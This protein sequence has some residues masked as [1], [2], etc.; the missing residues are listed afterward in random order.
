VEE[1]HRRVFQRPARRVGKPLVTQKARRGE[2]LAAVY[3]I[4]VV[5][6]LGAWI[7]DPSDV[8][9]P[10]GMVTLL[11]FAFACAVALFAFRER[12]PERTGD[13]AIVGSIVLISAGNLFC[14][15]HVHPG[16]LTPYYIWVGFASPMWFARRRAVAYVLVAV[17]ASGLVAVVDGTAVA[18][19]AWLI[20]VAVLVVAFLTVDSL[21]RA[22]VERERLAAVGEMASVVSHELRNPLAVLTNAIYLVRHA[23]GAALTPDLERHLDL[24]DR[25]IDKANAIIE[26]IVAFVRP[27]HPELVPVPLDQV[28]EEVLETTPP[29]PGVQVERDTPPVTA[30]VDR[31]HLAE[32]LVNLVSNAYEAMPDGGTV[33]ITARAGTA[34][35]RIAVEDTGRGF[36]RS[37]AERFFE[38]FYTTKPAGTGLGL[39]I[40][41]RLADINRGEIS[42]DSHPGQG[43]RFT[44]T[45]PAR[46]ADPVPTRLGSDEPVA[47][48]RAGGETTSDADLP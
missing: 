12:L 19:A 14:R 3:V 2:I 32:V 48:G 26:H 37:D 4:G 39:A 11:A 20:T 44:V 9:N 34:L 1:R 5:G 18:A 25:E 28:I 30:V 17:F 43:T 29:P 41:R 8:S 16:L 40:V 27:R 15:L 6:V 36:N 10:I 46:S 45:L 13:V 23:M 47:G 31:G 42:V 35:A 22:Q 24:A 33:R 38:P 7:A 21:T